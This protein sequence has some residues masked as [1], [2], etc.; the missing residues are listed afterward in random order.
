MT[1]IERGARPV[2]VIDDEFDLP[3]FA[4]DERSWSADLED[5]DMSEM[6]ED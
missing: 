5:A 3:D 4:W 6:E 1:R 2:P